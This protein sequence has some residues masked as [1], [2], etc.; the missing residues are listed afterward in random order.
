MI[1]YNSL[2]ERSVSSQNNISQYSVST[3]QWSRDHR[4]LLPALWQQPHH[5]PRGTLPGSHGHED[6]APQLL[7]YLDFHPCLVTF[8]HVYMI[9]VFAVRTGARSNLNGCLVLRTLKFH[10]YQEWAFII[11]SG[12]TCNNAPALIEFQILFLHSTIHR[13]NLEQIIGVLY[14]QLIPA[15]IPEP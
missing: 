13:N 8:P 9:L 1:W 11:K 5:T 2:S 12:H 15:N 6:K 3:P 7:F 4:C 14:K 10:H